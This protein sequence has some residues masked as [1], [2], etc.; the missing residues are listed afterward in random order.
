M[1][2]YGKIYR[3]MLFVQLV[4]QTACPFGNRPNPGAQEA[5]P[6]GN[7]KNVLELTHRAPSHMALMRFMLAFS[8]ASTYRQ[9]H[10]VWK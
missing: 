10:P 8:I 4:E 2:F 1:L 3:A 5:C 6:S 9:A 7:I